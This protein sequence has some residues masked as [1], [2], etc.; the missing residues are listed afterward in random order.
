MARE[1][2]EAFALVKVLGTFVLRVDLEVHSSTSGGG[3]DLE[4][5]AEHRPSDSAIAV[6][7]CDEELVEPCHATSVLQR[8]RIRENGDSDGIRVVRDEDRPAARIGQQAEHTCTEGLR[9]QVDPVLL[10]LRPKEVHGVVQG[11]DRR[12]FD[13]HLREP[14]HQTPEG[15]PDPG[16]DESPADRTFRVVTA[17]YV[18]RSAPRSSRRH[19]HRERRPTN[20]ENER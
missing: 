20:G 15:L 16:A 17:A 9:G 19:R 14:T 18:V 6:L 12:G 10:K 11:L 2:P 1:A 13:L 8:P 5:L 7:G 4:C 3:R